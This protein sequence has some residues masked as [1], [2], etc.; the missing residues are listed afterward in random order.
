MVY[1]HFH[2]KINNVAAAANALVTS[3]TFI[4][5]LCCWFFFLLLLLI[6]IG[7]DWNWRAFYTK[8]ITPYCQR[9]CWQWPRPSIKMR[10]QIQINVSVVVAMQ[11]IE[12]WSPLCVM[13]FCCC[14]P[15]SR[16]CFFFFHQI[17]KHK[18]KYKF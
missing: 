5:C 7:P 17:N 10:T 1:L 15:L 8:S 13:R 4:S 11:I 9:W 16:F 14:M 18:I 12:H 6:A 2:I 3:S